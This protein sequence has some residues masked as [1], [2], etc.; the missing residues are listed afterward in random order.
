MSLMW[1]RQPWTSKV[2][3]LVCSSAV[4]LVTP[5]FFMCLHSLSR[6]FV[7]CLPLAQVPSVLPLKTNFQTLSLSSCLRNPHSLDRI[8]FINSLCVSAMFIISPLLIWDL[9]IIILSKP[10]VM[11]SKVYAT[12]VRS[13]LMH[14]S[15]TWPMKFEHVLKMNCTEISMIRW[16]CGGWMKRW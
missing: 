3:H 12:C 16:M 11:N 13:C 14:G 9:H 10:H 5:V 2:L 15:E 7:L 4:L 1:H 6:Y 8:T